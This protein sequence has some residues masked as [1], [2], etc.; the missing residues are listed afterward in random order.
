MGNVGRVVDSKTNGQHKVDNRN[1]VDRYVPQPHDAN[2][3]KQNHGNVGDNNQARPPVRNEDDGHHTDGN[4]GLE[5]ARECLVPDNSILL[6][7]EP[8]ER[9]GPGVEVRVQV[10]DS[11]A[12]P[13]H[14]LDLGSAVAQWART[15]VDAAPH[16]D[17]NAA[18]A[19]ISHRR[20]AVLLV[21]KGGIHHGL[22]RLIRVEEVLER[23]T[24]LLGVLGAS[25][26][27]VHVVEHAP[28]QVPP[29]VQREGSILK[30]GLGQ[31]LDPI[32]E[33]LIP[34]VGRKVGPHARALRSRHEVCK[35]VIEHLGVL[36][37][38]PPAERAIRG[39]P[40][41]VRRR[42]QRGPFPGRDPSLHHRRRGGRQRHVRGQRAG[43]DGPIPNGG[44]ACQPVKASILGHPEKVGRQG[45]HV[46][47][48]EHVGR[49]VEQGV[50][51]RPT[52]KVGKLLHGLR[53][54][55][56]VKAVGGLVEV[57]SW[58]GVV[59]K[60]RHR[61]GP[62]AKLVV[63]NVKDRVE[64]R[65]RGHKEAKRKVLSQLGGAIGAHAKDAK[66]DDNDQNLD[67]KLDQGGRIVVLEKP[68]Q[69]APVLLARQAAARHTAPLLLHNL[70]VDK[71]KV[72]A[73]PLLS[74]TEPAA[75]AVPGGD[76]DTLLVPHARG[77]KEGDLE[78]KVK[79][80]SKRRPRAKVGESRK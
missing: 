55:G 62:R 35:H 21:P 72:A 56:G 34:L 36:D 51:E 57:G 64:G 37:V 50:N 32:S 22:E 65:V 4:D 67:G 2:D 24:K 54:L 71:A 48:L 8:R 68:S 53:D 17:P 3:V 59:K 46:G 29:L 52:L 26:A 19:I 14:N 79:Q 45:K 80:N 7:K 10:R 42:A 23:L 20:V 38:G 9:V 30:L 41:H 18:H 1:R 66:E 40:L 47:R 43:V 28:R 61:G 39:N 58:L 13:L 16:V 44:S 73:T 69:V 11:L 12:R 78:D 77:D 6:G 49:Q 33:S 25:G 5:D 31:R 27:V 15:L 60:H 74:A 75:V 63:L 70:L 76:L